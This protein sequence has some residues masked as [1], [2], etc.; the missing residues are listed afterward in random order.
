MDGFRRLRNFVT[1]FPASEKLH[2]DFELEA[3]TQRMERTT[4]ASKCMHVV[5]S[6]GF[7]SVL[8]LGILTICHSISIL[9]IIKIVMLSF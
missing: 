1:V 5:H 2:S 8:V 4:R 6:V 7:K 9:R 3:G